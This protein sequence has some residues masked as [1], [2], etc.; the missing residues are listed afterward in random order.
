MDHTE[1][2]CAVGNKKHGGA[3]RCA[4]SEPDAFL[5]S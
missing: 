1:E 5:Y 2:G 4:M 3:E